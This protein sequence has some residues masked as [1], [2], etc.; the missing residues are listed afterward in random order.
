STV[1]VVVCP[2]GGPTDPLHSLSVSPDGERLAS[3][4]DD[5]SICVWNVATGEI[6]ADPFKGHMDSINSI[7]F[8]P[9]G[10][11]LAS[12]SSDM[13]IRIWDARTSETVGL[14]EGH[15]GSVLSVS[16]S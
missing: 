3:G 12:G 16:F 9:D 14:F 4:S 6:V 5:K 1:G 7:L 13:S 8:S 15:T 2:L 10:K 11:R